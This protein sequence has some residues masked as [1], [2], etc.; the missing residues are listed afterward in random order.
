[1]LLLVTL[2]PSLCV[3]LQK[4]FVGKLLTAATSGL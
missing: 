2:T 1:M 4:A 3:V